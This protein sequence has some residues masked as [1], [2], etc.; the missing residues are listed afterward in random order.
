MEDVYVPVIVF[1][2]FTTAIAVFFAIILGLD[3]QSYEKTYGEDSPYDIHE[4]GT[5]CGVD[6]INI[7]K[8]LVYPIATSSNRDKDYH[9]IQPINVTFPDK[10]KE[11]R[12][13]VVK[14][15]KTKEQLFEYIDQ[16]HFDEKVLAK[17]KELNE[18]RNKT[19]AGTDAYL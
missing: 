11:Q 7:S 13:V 1:L 4:S 6:W 16:K 3:N 10:T 5:R 9:I 17:A 18:E 19:R 2:S 8:F 15:F 12:Y 14:S